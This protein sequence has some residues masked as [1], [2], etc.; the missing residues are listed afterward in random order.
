MPDSSYSAVFGALAQQNRLDVIANNLANVNT[1][2]FKGDKLA[3][4]DTFERYAHDLVDPNQTLDSK[5]QWPKS[6]VLAQSRIAER[7]IDFSQGNLKTTGN[8]LDL[9]ISGEGFFKVQTS[10]G[11][12]LTRQGCYH[13]S[14]EGFI[15]DGHGNKLLGEGGPIQLP[16][17]AG[18]LTIDEQGTLSVDGEILDQIALVT[19]ADP[20]VLEK[21]G[22]SL[23]RIDPDSKAQPIPA[24]NAT[25]E[26]GFLEAA[27][28]EVVTE[29]VNMIEATRAFEAYQK[30]ITGTFDQDKKAIAEVGA[31]K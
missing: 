26:Q 10:D 5:V 30:I 6:Y 21:V 16:E 14:S 9:A 31:P 25:I 4:R 13:R 3:F 23:L 15:V 24:E 18:T 1:T 2:G 7:V 17:N 22:N 20:K 12:F 29:M 11:E 27:N 19:V 8:P 28:V